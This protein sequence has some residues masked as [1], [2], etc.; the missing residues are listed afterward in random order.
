MIIYSGFYSAS[1]LPLVHDSRESVLLSLTHNALSDRLLNIDSF[2]RAL[3]SK[4]FVCISRARTLYRLHVIY[5]APHRAFFMYSVHILQTLHRIAL[6]QLE[7]A[8][9]SFDL[10]LFQSEPKFVKHG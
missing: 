2:Q 7:K 8:C 10:F 4:Y 6:C 1:S 3:W 5:A 9:M